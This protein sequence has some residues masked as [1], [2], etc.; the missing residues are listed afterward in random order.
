MRSSRGGN[1]KKQIKSVKMANLGNVCLCALEGQIQTKINREK[2]KKK[3]G[4]WSF[5]EVDCH[6]GR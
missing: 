3:N 6:I 2:G 5:V 1:T 4:W